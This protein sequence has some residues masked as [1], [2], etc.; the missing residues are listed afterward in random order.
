MDSNHELEATKYI[1][2]PDALVALCESVTSKFLNSINDSELRQKQAQLIEVS[3]SIDQLTKLSVSIPDELR[4]LKIG[5]VTELETQTQ[6]KI[7]L[8]NILMGLKEIVK[9]IE[10]TYSTNSPKKKRTHRRRS[11]SGLPQTNQKLYRNEIIDALKI[12][13]GS[14]THLEVID[15]IEE[16]MKGKLLEG[17]FEKRAGGLLVWKNNVHWA[18]NSL[19]DD[20]ILRSDSPRGTWELSEEYKCDS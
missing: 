19:K 12:L 16:S 2:D 7:K 6:S 11:K 8:E 1:E 20:G 14:G 10:V 9:H 3:R 5:L 13:G 17:D 18:R 4:N 15:I